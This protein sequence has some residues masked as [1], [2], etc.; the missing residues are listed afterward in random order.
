[1]ISK[2]VVHCFTIGG[3]NVKTASNLGSGE[4]ETLTFKPTQQGIFTYA[5]LMH[6]QMAGKNHRSMSAGHFARLR[7][8]G[9]RLI[10]IISPQTCSIK[11]LSGAARRLDKAT[12]RR[13]LSAAAAR[14][15]HCS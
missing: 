5:C 15:G 11:D 3:L 10:I 1:M 12:W 6:P 13:G 14:R 9:N 2:Q 8:R 7:F 4:T